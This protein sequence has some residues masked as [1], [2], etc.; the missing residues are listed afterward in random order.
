MEL[1]FQM[2]VSCFEGA[3][4]P[5]KVSCRSSKWSSELSSP[6]P[7]PRLRVLVKEPAG[8]RGLRDLSKV[9]KKTGE[10]G[11]DLSGPNQALYI[12]LPAWTATLSLQHLH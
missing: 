1:D 6:H 8:Q 4:N 12:G 11:P 9:L 10:G 2:V 7:S 3:R 5:T